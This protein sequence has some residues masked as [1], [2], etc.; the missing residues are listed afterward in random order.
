MSVKKFPVEIVSCGLYSGWD[1]TSKDLPK[2]KRSTT[3]VPGQLDVEFGYIVNIR[4]ARGEKLDYCIDHPPFN[5]SNG[6]PAPPFTG[7]VHIKSNDWDF[8]LGDTLWEPLS[9]KIGSWRL[10]LSIRGRMVAEETFDVVA[11]S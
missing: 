11:E 6:E 3:T 1:P 5:G 7:T 4:K 9:D 2:F 8:F 10:T